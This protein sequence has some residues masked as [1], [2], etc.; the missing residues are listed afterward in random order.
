MSNECLQSPNRGICHDQEREQIQNVQ[1]A[2]K[3]NTKQI[4][5]SSQT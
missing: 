1:Y 2:S 5:N 4:V 3:Q